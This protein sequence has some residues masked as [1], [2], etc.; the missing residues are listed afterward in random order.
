MKDRHKKL[1]D[2]TSEQHVQNI[3]EKQTKVLDVNK[4]SYNKGKKTEK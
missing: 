2:K 4:T 1:M 3:A